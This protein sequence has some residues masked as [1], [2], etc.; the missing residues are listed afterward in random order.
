MDLYLEMYYSMNP[1]IQ[2]RYVNYFV[3]VQSNRL[4]R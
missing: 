2:I 3:F 1:N 4:L